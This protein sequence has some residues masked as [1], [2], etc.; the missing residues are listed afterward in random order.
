MRG[1]ASTAAST[2]GRSSERLSRRSVCS[3]WWRPK[4][5]APRSRML[6]ARPWRSQMPKQ[7]VAQE[8]AAGPVALGEVRGELEA[9]LVHSAAPTACPRATAAK[10]TTSEPSRLASGDTELIVL[11]QAMALE[12]PGRQRG[13][14]AERRRPGED[15][16]VAGQR[17]ARHAA[18]QRRARDV[19]HERP[20]RELTPPA[21]AA[22]SPTRP[23][24]TNRAIEPVP[25]SS[26]TSSH[27]PSVI[28]PSARAGRARWPA[29]PRRSRPPAWPPRTPTASPHSCA[30]VILKSSS[31][32]VENVVSAPHTPVPRKGRL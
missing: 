29:R 10:P 4:P 5:S 13:V 7:R 30:R 9:V 18:Q 8:P 3:T 21:A 19:D 20:P 6:V 25:P 17:R 23:S 1:R 24:T 2:I 14:G 32:T 16:C 27:V 11:P 28:G 15:E 12:H 31:C 26:A 22:R